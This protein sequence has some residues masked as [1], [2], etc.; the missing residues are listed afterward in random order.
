MH[1]PNIPNC[2]QFS[3]NVGYPIKDRG[4]DLLVEEKN[5]TPEI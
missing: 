5:C 2:F 4:D 3:N 1:D